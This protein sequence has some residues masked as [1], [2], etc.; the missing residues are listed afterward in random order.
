M[1]KKEKQMRIF[2]EIKIN[3]IKGTVLVSDTFIEGD[4][5]KSSIVIDINQKV[6]DAIFQNLTRNKGVANIII[7]T[8]EAAFTK[9]K[10]ISVYTDCDYAVE[11]VARVFLVVYDYKKQLGE[12]DE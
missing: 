6:D 1:K 10:K 8:G 4:D 3:G 2:G 11:S 12:I 7:E 5:L 9:F